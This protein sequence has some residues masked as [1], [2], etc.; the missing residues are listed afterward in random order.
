M[1]SR[2]LAVPLGRNTTMGPP[3]GSCWFYTLF[4]PSLL[5]PFR[6]FLQ[7][8]GSIECAESFISRAFHISGF[9]WSERGASCRSFFPWF[10]LSR[11]KC[12]EFLDFH[13]ASIFHCQPQDVLMLLI[14]SL[15]AQFLR[16]YIEG[17]FPAPEQIGTSKTT[18]FFHPQRS[19]SFGTL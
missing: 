18:V 13:K 14:R 12:W 4:T 15:G 17:S 16:F 11:K 6:I 9:G 19:Q 10:P 8:A 5:P 7:F 3:E 1:A 2:P